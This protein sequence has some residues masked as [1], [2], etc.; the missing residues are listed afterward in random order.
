MALLLLS[1]ADPHHITSVPDSGPADT[2]PLIEIAERAG[3]VRVAAYLHRKLDSI[4]IPKGTAANSPVSIPVSSTAY[5]P[6]STC[7]SASAS[8]SASTPVKA[9]LGPQSAID[10]P[11]ACSP[12]SATPY[13]EQSI[14]LA[15]TST[16]DAVDCETEMSTLAEETAPIPAAIPPVTAVTAISSRNEVEEEDDLEDFYEALMKDFPVPKTLP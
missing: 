8:A 9:T 16:Q 6:V 2:I 13:T 15:A 3:H 4:V 11:Q 5:V 12:E 7:S 1:G 10:H 14:I